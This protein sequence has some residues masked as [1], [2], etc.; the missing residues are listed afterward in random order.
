MSVEENQL[1]DGLKISRKG[2]LLSRDNVP[3]DIIIG[4]FGDENSMTK[5]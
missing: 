1:E 4:H 2:Y 3:L 5:G